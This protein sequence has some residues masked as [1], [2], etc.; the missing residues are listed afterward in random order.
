MPKWHNAKKPSK[1]IYDNFKEMSLQKYEIYLGSR[2]HLSPRSYFSSGSKALLRGFLLY[3][4]DSERPG[5]V[6]KDEVASY[7]YWNEY[8]DLKLS[9]TMIYYKKQQT[10]T[11]I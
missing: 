3:N 6:A 1:I 10:I 9:N 5:W 4:E 2:I 7:L 11:I 8:N